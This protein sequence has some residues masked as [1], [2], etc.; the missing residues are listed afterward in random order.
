MSASEATF[1]IY[2]TVLYKGEPDTLITAVVEGPKGRALLVFRSE[3][4]AEKYRAGTGN[5]PE[6][7][8]WRPVALGL[9]E[10]SE[11]IAMHGCSHVAMPEE[12]TGKGPVDFF[13]AAD[14]LAFLD[15][16]EPAG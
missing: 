4:E 3:G 7:E 15:E 10:L 12:W 1:T 9:K 8:G 5:N 14:F 11:V 6:T 2:P 13:A 16:C